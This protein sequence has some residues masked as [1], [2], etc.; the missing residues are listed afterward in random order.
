VGSV[1]DS[2]IQKNRSGI[3][4]REIPLAGRATI[5]AVEFHDDFTLMEIGVSDVRADHAAAKTILPE[6]ERL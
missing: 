6:G 5:I 3:S 4:H 2:V 1:I